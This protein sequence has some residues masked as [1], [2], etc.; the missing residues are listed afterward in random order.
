LLMPMKK[1]EAVRY[2]AGKASPCVTYHAGWLG[3][4]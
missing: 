4:E 3:G 2:A 1:R